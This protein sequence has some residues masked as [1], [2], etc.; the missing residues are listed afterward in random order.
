MKV[1]LELDEM[2]ICCLECP[3]AHWNSQGQLQCNQKDENGV[4]L[5]WK[6][7]QRKRRSDCPLKEVE[8]SN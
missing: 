5:T 6:A 3:C 2:P 1:I 8:E 4:M 7:Y